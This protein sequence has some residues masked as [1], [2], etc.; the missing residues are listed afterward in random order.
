[1]GEQSEKVILGLILE[2]KSLKRS[3]ES[4]L[5]EVNYFRSRFLEIL[6]NLIK[7]LTAFDSFS[8]IRIKPRLKKIVRLFLAPFTKVFNSPVVSNS[9]PNWRIILKIIV[10]L[11]KLE[12]IKFSHFYILNLFHLFF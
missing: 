3:L 8:S 6:C 7:M 4:T 11:S 9:H 10:T 1:M 5:L 2:N 12:K